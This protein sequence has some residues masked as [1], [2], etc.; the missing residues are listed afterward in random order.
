MMKFF[1]YLSVILPAWVSNL[2]AAQPTNA[3]A[4][5]DFE[6]TG[7]TDETKDCAFGL[8]DVLAV[9]L[10]QRGVV[11]FERQQIRVV[12]GERRITASGLMRWQKNHS[13]EIPDLAYLVAG[14]LRAP[15]RQRFQLEVSLV[16]AQT[17]RNAA[18]FTGEGQYPKD[19]PRTLAELAGQ[20]SRHLKSA[21]GNTASVEPPATQSSFRTPEVA[22]LFYKGIAYCMAGQPELGV[23]WFMDAEKAAPTFLPARV[24]EMRAFEMLG[25]TD[26]AAIARQRLRET[27]NGPGVLNR[28]NT[29]RFL[30]QN[31]ISVAM[32]PDPRLN[33]DGLK[34][35]TRLKNLLGQQST[36]FVAD[37]ANIHALAAEM[38]L[39]LTE[40]GAHDLE[41]TSM[42]WSSMDALVLVSG[43]PAHPGELSVQLRDALSGEILFST[44]V[45]A[46]ASQLKKLAG[47]LAEKISATRTT[48]GSALKIRSNAPAIKPV[49]VTNTDRTEFAG[50]LR[51]LSENPSDRPAWMR[52]ALFFPWLSDWRYPCAC[53]DRVRIGTDLSEPDAAHWISDA[54]WHKRGYEGTSRGG[55]PAPSIQTEAAVLFSHFPASPEAAYARSALTLELIDRTNYAAAVPIL[56]ELDKALPELAK[57]VEIGPAYRAN[58]FF[59]AAAALHE[60]GD[61]VRARQFLARADEVL[62]QNPD[63][64]IYDGN[65]YQLG[66]WVNH[67]PVSHPLFGKERS[68]RQAV[69]EWGERLNPP[70]KIDGKEVIT[71]GQLE[72][73]LD[74]A[75]QTSGPAQSAQLLDFLKRLAEHKQF[76][77]EQYQGRI[78]DTDPRE[79]WRQIRLWNATTAGNYTLLGKLM[80]EAPGVVKQVFQDAA[81]P[82][83]KEE[84]RSVAH[85]LAASLI[86]EIA[87]GFYDA[88]DEYE[89]ALGKIEEAIGHPA[90]YPDTPSGRTNLPFKQAQDAA[91][92]RLEKIHLLQA[93]GKHRAAAEYATSQ[94]PAEEETPRWERVDPGSKNNTATYLTDDK[95][96][97]YACRDAA[98]AW[99]AAGQPDKAC[100]IFAKYARTCGPVDKMNAHGATVCIFW[101]D[102]EAA[103]GNRSEAAEI[104]RGVVR[105]SE[106]KDWGV[107]LRTGYANAYNA[108]ISRLEKLRSDTEFQ[109]IST[110]WEHPPKP[111]P[112]AEGTNSS[113]MR[114]DLD[115]LLRGTSTGPNQRSYGG[116]QIGAFISKYGHSCVPVV[117]SA[118]QGGEFSAHLITTF[119]I[120]QQTATPADAAQV[121][122]AF[123]TV[124]QLAQTAFQLDSTNAAVILRERFGFY[125]HG[126]NIPQELM[127]VVEKFQLKD[128]YPVLI[129]NFAGKDVNGATAPNAAAVDRILQHDPDPE[130]L[131][132]FRQALAA[133]IQKQLLM[134]YRYGLASL[135]ET[136]MRN[137]VPEGIEAVLRSDDN[138]ATNCPACLRKFIELPADDSAARGMAESGLGRWQWEGQTKKF[139][140]GQNKESKSALLMGASSHRTNNII[141]NP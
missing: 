124:P 55:G 121:L 4:V 56:L 129:A 118:A 17:G 45:K 52:L 139:T 54:I 29:S 58:L 83:Q 63:L 39:Q 80:V 7:T 85:A 114:R 79:P 68:L 134:K 87:A 93:L 86:P 50:L 127:Q 99:I 34:L 28:L 2:A 96:K 120:L 132:L 51:F 16:E 141:S 37:P 40:Q 100:E 103:R 112:A 64:I 105:Q 119:G 11:L 27:P 32:I 135:G 5:A 8:A 71:L 95:G 140:L 44:A 15:D 91:N 59:F 53:F 25:L 92:L 128:Q 111:A 22:L 30:N 101:A 74:L 75:R 43:D 107:Y 131:R 130:S 115:E 66:V 67:F 104:L 13:A 136:A 31:L 94:I 113:D 110:D 122:E 9:E 76:H 46:D 23:T 126:G 106:G 21:A 89:L 3:V 49:Q 19:L 14:N 60:T 109:V 77:P 18:T 26:F 62:R 61:D 41:L 65:T 24:W 88:T 125:G 1:I 123:K 98:D 42:L 116:P 81:S 138:N 90:A 97:L 38:D 36:F 70:A 69:A 35:A 47:Q 137:G 33:A 73:L 57:Q 6:S 12:L 48:V 78:T 84:V 10:Q 20:I 102:Y 108:S 117:L 133:T 72:S 82:A